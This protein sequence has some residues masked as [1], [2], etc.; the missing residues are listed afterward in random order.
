MS[1][2][3]GMAPHQLD[4]VPAF[5]RSA[6]ELQGHVARLGADRVAAALRVAVA[7]LEP[8]SPAGSR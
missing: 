6:A 2:R 8:C 5:S 4:V 3:N 1:N 7:D